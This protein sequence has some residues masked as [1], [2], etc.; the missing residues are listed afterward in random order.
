MGLWGKMRGHDLAEGKMALPLFGSSNATKREQALFYLMPLE[1][2]SA[3]A[4]RVVEIV[5]NSGALGI[6]AKV[7][8]EEINENGNT[9][10]R[11]KPVSTRVI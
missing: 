9:L 6:N 8:D 3:E 1:N 11:I 7:R 5:N 10:R 2:R 4:T